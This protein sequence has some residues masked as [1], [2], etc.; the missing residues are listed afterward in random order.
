MIEIEAIDMFVERD[1]EMDE[2]SEGNSLISLRV[3]SDR[4]FSREIKELGAKWD[5]AAKE[6]RLVGNETTVK[7]IGAL[8]KVVFPK[9]PRRRNRLVAAQVSTSEES[10]QPGVAGQEASPTQPPQKEVI[11]RVEF[12][13][14]RMIKNY[15]RG[16]N[17]W[18]K[19]FRQDFEQ[20]AQ[21][22]SSQQQ[23]WPVSLTSRE[24]PEAMKLN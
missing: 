12:V 10:S 16:Q 7:Q 1:P 15:R 21:T 9:L 6:W 18:V 13:V 19:E 14:N 11:V 3:P 20:P 23:P 17:L 8:C 22:A 5:D 4:E 2:D 24:K